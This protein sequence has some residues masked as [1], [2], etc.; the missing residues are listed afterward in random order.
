MTSPKMKVPGRA[1]ASAEPE[2]NGL[3]SRSGKGFEGD[4]V[5]EGFELSDVLVLLGVGV[6]VSGVVVGAE[7]V[8]VGLGVGE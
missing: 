8:E 1:T 7:V 3:N 5:A 2:W 6:D 4:L